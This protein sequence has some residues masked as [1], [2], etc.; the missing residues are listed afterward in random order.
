MGLSGISVVGVAALAGCA[1]GP[2]FGSVSDGLRT[3]AGADGSSAS[4]VRGPSSPGAR[5]LQPES[6]SNSRK[7]RSP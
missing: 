5:P 3:N 2:R 7:R 6:G 4:S 1:L